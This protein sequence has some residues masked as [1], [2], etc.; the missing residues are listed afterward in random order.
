M[1]RILLP[2]TSVKCIPADFKED[3]DNEDDPSIFL[4]RDITF[5]PEVDEH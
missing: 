4:R 2:L 1:A 3:P 5:D